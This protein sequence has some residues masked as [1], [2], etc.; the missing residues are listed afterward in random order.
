ARSALISLPAGTAL[1]AGELAAPALSA[2][3]ILL[4]AAMTAAAALPLIA[5]AVAASILLIAGLLIAAAASVSRAAPRIPGN[6]RDVG[7]SA[8]VTALSAAACKALLRTVV[9]RPVFFIRRLS[10]GCSVV[11]LGISCRP[12]R[13]MLPPRVR[14]PV[15]ESHAS[16][17]ARNALHAVGRPARAAAA[18]RLRRSRLK[19]GLLRFR[20][21]SSCSLRRDPLQNKISAAE[22]AILLQV[23]LQRRDDRILRPLIAPFLE[24][25][26]QP[27][28]II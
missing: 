7:A 6:S 15:A 20:S 22:V 13:L 11:P 4:P 21:R 24:E 18:F 9:L 16:G 10:G 28:L 8:P 17:N 5:A 2:A 1:P 26:L 12:R 23:I 3:G 19:D 27:Q 14:L 25:A